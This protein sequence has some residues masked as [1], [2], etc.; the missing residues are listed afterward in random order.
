VE[1]NCRGLFG[2]QPQHLIEKTEKSDKD[3]QGS[4]PLNRDSKP[5]PSDCDTD[6]LTTQ[7]RCSVVLGPEG[8]CLLRRVVRWKSTGLFRRNMSPPS[9]GTKNKTSKKPA[10]KQVTRR[11]I[12][13]DR[14]LRI[15]RCEIFKFYVLV[16]IDPTSATL[17]DPKIELHESN[18]RFIMQKLIHDINQRYY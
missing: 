7:P 3:D 17:F 13:E 18:Q 16:L 10:R 14:T 12:P 6:V 11:Y 1:E 2:L 5:R 9:S 4:E 8:V 15:Y